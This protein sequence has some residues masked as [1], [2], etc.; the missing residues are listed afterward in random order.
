M[1]TGYN[2]WCQDH[3]EDVKAWVQTKGQEGTKAQVQRQLF[4]EWMNS[5]PQ[6]E[7]DCYNDCA[8]MENEKRKAEEEAQKQNK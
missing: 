3:Y 2:L 1:L 5:L 6:S 7:R 8:K 4:W